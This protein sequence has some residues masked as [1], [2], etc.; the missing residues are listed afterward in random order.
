MMNKRIRQLRDLININRR[1]V[2]E[3]SDGKIKSRAL[4]SIES[5]RSSVSIEMLQAI[6]DF[7]NKHN[8]VISYE[9]IIT[10]VGKPPY[11]LDK[12]ILNTTN[13][14][15]Y[16]E[17]KYFEDLNP[18]S[19]SLTVQDNK[20]VPFCKIGDL[21]GGIQVEEKAFSNE[22]VITKVNNNIN[23]YKIK[24]YEDR[25]VHVLMDAKNEIQEIV[26]FKEIE[27]FY[28]IVWVRSYL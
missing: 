28:K 6:H 1:E 16:K 2:E 22:Y 23:T 11:M 13:I 14:N 15:I 8:I 3:L 19:I 18:R 7:Y 10:G 27:Y 4:E 17:A 26:T 20:L 5:G 9:W 12:S 25:N 21:I 24:S